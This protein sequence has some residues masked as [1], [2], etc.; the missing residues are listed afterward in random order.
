M[1]P[2]EIEGGETQLQHGREDQVGGAHREGWV[3]GSSSWNPVSPA[4][5]NDERGSQQRGKVAKVVRGLR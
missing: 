2:E 5:G 4:V 1:A 3:D